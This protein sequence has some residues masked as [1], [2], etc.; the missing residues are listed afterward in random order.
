MHQWSNGTWRL[1]SESYVTVNKRRQ[2]LIK[3][4]YLDVNEF[5]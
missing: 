3:G 1:G 5:V 2:R 4:L